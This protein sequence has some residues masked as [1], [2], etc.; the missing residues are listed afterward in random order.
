MNA[1]AILMMMSVDEIKKLW[2]LFLF[3]NY[4]IEI[5]Y[6]TILVFF[7]L[8]TY[9]TTNI[10]IIDIL[11]KYFHQNFTVCKNLYYPKQF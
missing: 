11:F 6:H 1:Q 4:E 9:I 3:G 8:N 10:T 7:L 5:K 2:L